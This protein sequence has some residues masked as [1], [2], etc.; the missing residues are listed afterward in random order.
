MA[1]PERVAEVFAGME[2]MGGKMLDAAKTALEQRAM[3]RFADMR[4]RRQAYELM[5]PIEDG[6]ITRASLDFLGA[7][8]HRKH[9]QTYGHSNPAEPV[10]IVNLRLTAIGRLTP[11]A[12]AQKAK[13]A[14]PTGTREVWFP[15][16]GFI[17]C[18]VYWREGLAAGSRLPGPV[19][20]E[21]VD[22]TT[23]VPPGWTTKVDERGYLLIQGAQ[24]C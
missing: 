21:S 19:V 14:R 23:V 12:L 1:S 20:I 17:E 8:F 11:V 24:P 22:S 9:E 6:P 4:Y 7:T 10:E 16:T 18:S 2:E 5:V 15:R 13:A 3:L